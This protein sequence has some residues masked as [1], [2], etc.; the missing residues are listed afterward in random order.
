MGVS[1]GYLPY[2]WL[3]WLETELEKDGASTTKILLPHH[4]LYPTD[5]PSIDPYIDPDTDCLVDNGQNNI[6]ELCLNYKNINSVLSQ[7][8][9][10]VSV[11]PHSYQFESEGYWEPGSNGVYYV[12]KEHYMD[13]NAD[14]VTG[15]YVHIDASSS[16]CTITTI[17]DGGGTTTIMDVTF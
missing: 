6:Y 9:Q 8:S 4:H 12:W 7:F 10:V 1:R 2:K 16:G 15:T 3:R 5:D 13:V 14:S 17:R 11:H